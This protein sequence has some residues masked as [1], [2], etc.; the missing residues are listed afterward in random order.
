M[1]YYK[2]K[3]D[4]TYIASANEKHTLYK[5]FT[6]NGSVRGWSANNCPYHVCC[7]AVFSLRDYNEISEKEYNEAYSIFNQ[8]FL[9]YK[10]DEGC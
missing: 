8:S 6:S 4:E 2:S 3:Y 10:C 7:M 1:K 5:T 9:N